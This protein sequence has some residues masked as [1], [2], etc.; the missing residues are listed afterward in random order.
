MSMQTL[1]GSGYKRQVGKVAMPPIRKH[2]CPFFSANV[3]GKCCQHGSTVYWE[4][5]VVKIF[6]QMP[7][8]TNIYHAKF[9]TNTEENDYARN[10]HG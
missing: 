4:I 7:L 6:S 2:L 5:F 9:H 3:V 8:D 1:A 10:E